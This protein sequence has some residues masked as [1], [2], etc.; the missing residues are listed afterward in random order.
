M[1]VDSSNY[2]TIAQGITRG[3]LPYRDFV[4]NKGPL[5]YLISVP[6]LALGGFTGVWLTELLL[7]CIS[8]LFAYKTALFFAGK[9]RAI[10][11]SACSF[12]IALTFFSV[13][14]GTEEYTLPFLMVSFYIFTKYF[15]SEQK[16]ISFFEL[17]ILGFCCASAV[18]IRLNM[19]PLWFGFC[20][21]I[22][23]E[24]LRS[25]RFALLGKYTAGF[26]LGILVISVPVF[27]YLQ[28][29]NILSDFI[30]QVIVGGAS[31]GFGG[32]GGLKQLVKNF[33]ITID[34][35]YCIV[36][37]TLGIFWC[38]IKFKKSGFSY[39]A[40]YTLS[41]ILMVL[42]LSFSLGDS[43]YN[44]VLVPFFIPPLAS[45]AAIIY[46]SFSSLKYKNMAFIVF[47]CIIF[48][49]MILKY[50]DD[51][52]EVFHNNSGKDLIAAGKMI[53]ENTAPGDTIISLGINGYIYP[54]TLRRAAS[55]YIYQ[56]SGTYYIPHAQEEFISDILN[57]KP[58]IIAI[59]T[60]EDNDRYDYLPEWYA[61]VFALIEQDYSLL[62]DKNGYVLFKKGISKN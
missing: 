1:H 3:G 35:M 37:L 51:V 30:T 61:P 25:R 17:I 2:I 45:F 57:N 34:R 19:F 18:L 12:V 60:A 55:K 20:V 54:F 8:V 43:H 28:A 44:M 62:S 40:G 10:F 38:I 4:D 32:E 42:F 27:F 5:A 21:V 49:G 41:Y 36:P 24:M 58:E 31:K 26:S 13:C 39:A 56:G 7:A 50:F 29:N 46:N 47:F 53:D 15:F 33:Y 11:A 14:A 23:I 22:F 16:N 48:S 6:G 59:F 9:H 52:M